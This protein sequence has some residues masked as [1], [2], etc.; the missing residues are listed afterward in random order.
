MRTRSFRLARRFVAL[1]ALLGASGSPEAAGEPARS[2]FRVCLLGTGIPIPNAERASASTLV[3]AGGTA[4][5]FDTGRGF[6]ANLAEAGRRDVDA[7]FYTHYHSDHFAEIGEFLVARTVF[8]ASEPLPVLGPP[9]AK[10]VLEGIAAA[11]SLDL[12]YRTAHHG[13]KYARAGVSAAVVETEPGVVYERDG[14]R[15]VMFPVEH[16]PVAPAVGYRV[17]F[18]G[19]SVV[20]SGDTKRCATVEE[21][22]AGCDLLIHEGY[23]ERMSRVQLAGAGGP[24]SRMGKMIVEM[25]EYHTTTLEVAEIAKAAGVKAVALT[26]LV[27]SIPPDDRTEAIFVQGMAAIYDGPISC[28]RDLMWFDIE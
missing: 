16:A 23:N 3:V 25:M 4:L 7:V 13:E 19:R 10:R 12:D 2:D 14:V 22:A 20:I 6:L 9:G 1:L 28:G 24:E 21:M 26:H 15:V 11:Y 5:L 18:G 8:G 27:P 17:E